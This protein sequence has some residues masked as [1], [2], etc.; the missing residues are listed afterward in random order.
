MSWFKRRRPDRIFDTGHDGDDE[1]LAQISRRSD[2]TKPR[3]WVHYLYCPNRAAAEQAAHDATDAGWGIQAV[4]PAAQGANW[5]VIADKHDA[6]TS[7]TAV[8]D[9][10]TLFEGIAARVGGQYDGWEAQ[11]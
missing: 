5:L 9:A 1:L 10:R 11:V 8:Q 7:P 4:E 3:H 6:V 2:L